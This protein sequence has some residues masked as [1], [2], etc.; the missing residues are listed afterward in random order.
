MESLQKKDYDGCERLEKRNKN[1]VPYFVPQITEDFL[2]DCE[3]DWLV[4]HLQRMIDIDFRN[5]ANTSKSLNAEYRKK[6]VSQIKDD[7][8]M[9]DSAKVEAMAKLLLQ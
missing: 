5:W 1:Q 2:G 3:P 9:T 4:R 6:R 7:T 8:E